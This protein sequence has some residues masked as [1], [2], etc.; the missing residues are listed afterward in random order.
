M[1]TP[2]KPKF[3]KTLPHYCTNQRTLR[4]NLTGKIKMITSRVEI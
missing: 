4:S 2:R 3:A 1:K